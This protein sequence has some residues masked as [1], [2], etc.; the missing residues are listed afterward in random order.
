M[1]FTKS[2][3]PLCKTPIDAQVNIRKNKV[4]LRKRCRDHGG[5]E[6]LVY[7]DAEEY[8]SSARFNKPG[9]IPLT[10]QTDVRDGCPSDCGL[11]PEHKQ[12]ACLGIIEVNTGCNLDW[13]ICFADSGHHSDGYSITHEQC[14]RMLDAFVA[15]EGEAEVVMFSGGE[16]TIHKHIWTSST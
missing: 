5:F 6:A 15:C 3:C 9:T 2:I 16:P 7:G 1:E 10:F 8:L 12:H 13:P 14:A 4:Y 11:C